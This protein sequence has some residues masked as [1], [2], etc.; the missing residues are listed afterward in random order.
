MD[1]KL[2]LYGSGKIGISW[3]ERLGEE[4]VY[5]FAD[6]DCQKANGKI[7]RKKVLS[8][9]ELLI[10]KNEIVVFIA[11]SYQY[12]KEIYRFLREN[13]IE[14]QLV[15][16]PLFGKNIYVDWNSYI[17]V[18]TTFEGRNAVSANGQLYG[19]EIGFASYISFDTILRNVR[20]GKYTSIG[21][22][23]RVIVGQHPTEKFVSTHPMFY[24]THSNVRKSYT[25][26]M[27]FEEFRY[28]KNGYSVEIGNDVWIGDGVTIM[29]GICIADG[30][31]VAAGANVIKDTEP[32]SIVGGNPAKL[33]RY[34]FKQEDIKFLLNLKWW[35]RGEAWIDEYAKYFNDIKY[36]RENII[37][38]EKSN[39]TRDISI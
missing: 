33:I 4:N 9:E 6:S 11:T 28:T 34:R 15:G 19:C 13:H 37:I 8:I 36:L 31:I 29:E 25:S 30:T 18:S 10:M 23:V 1:K 22:N 7:Q 12:K 35:D 38:G 2:I 26:E 21:P 17:D 24:S 5:A 14:E 16:Y 27:L 39:A 3:L 20:V 32:Y